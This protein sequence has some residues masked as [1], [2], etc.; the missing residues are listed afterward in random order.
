MQQ[1][2]V[3]VDDEP[4]IVEAIKRSTRLWLRDNG[5]ELVPFTN[6]QEAQEFIME[7]GK[8]VLIV[9]SDQKMPGII[10]SELLGTVRDTFPNIVGLIL[11]GQSD[12]RD[13]PHMV[14]AEV[15]AFIEKPWDEGGLVLEL[16]R[17]LQYAELRSQRDRYEYRSREDLRS[18]IE[19]QQVLLDIELPDMPGL[20]IA[21]AYRASKERPI[22]GDYHDIFAL[23]A[24][25]LLICTADVAGSGVKPAFIAA[26]LK[27]ILYSD[28]VRL[29]KPDELSVGKLVLWLNQRM[30][31]YLQKFPDLFLTFSATI[32]DTHKM[33]IHHA[34]AGQPPLMVLRNS[35][36]DLFG[37]G[38]MAVGIAD[39]VLVDE[40]HIEVQPGTQFALCSDGFFN[41][42]IHGENS[43]DRITTFIREQES[44]L[45]DPEHL[46]T[47]AVESMAA[48]PEA[49]DDIT[50]ISG[51][52]L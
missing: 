41:L 2:L 17:A 1:L 35:G 16:E 3:V 25:H 14:R 22:G 19:F 21:R 38:G 47:V 12:T 11:S 37:T 44:I 13:I 6:S 26:V 27:S 9:L 34:N 15:F 36:I 30:V 32:I 20:G 7:H 18:A 5:L 29:Y 10:G 49:V 46:V 45:G 40:Q 31:K 8:D 51:R 24:T 48:D 28:F 52:F 42:A 50:V 39:R 4:Q 23:D 33:V 43:T